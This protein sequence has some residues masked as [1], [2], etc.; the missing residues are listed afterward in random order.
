MTVSLDALLDTPF[1]AGLGIRSRPA[2][3][4]EITHLTLVE[5]ISDSAALSPGAVAVLTRGCG[6]SAGGYQLDVLIRRAAERDVAAVVLPC[7]V[8]RSPTAEHL[9]TRGRVILLDVDDELDPSNVVDGL[10]AAIAGDA[11]LALRRLAAASRRPPSAA[12]AAVIVGEIAEVTGIG[13]RYDPSGETGERVEVDGRTRGSVTT[14]DRDDSAII[15]TRLAALTVSQALTRSDRETLLPLRSTS[16]A[17]SHLLLCSQA[18]LANVAVRASETGLAV[19]GWH[20]AVRLVTL[21]PDHGEGRLAELEHEVIDIIAGMRRSGGASWSVVRPDDSLVLVL[22]TR[23]S[24]GR[25]G[26]RVVSE[27]V[28]TVVTELLTRHP[29]VSLRVGI[30][31]PHEGA[32]G[33]RVSAEES[34]TAV[35]SAGLSSGPVSVARF[36]SLG[37]RRMLAEWLVTDTA[38][39]TVSSLLAPLDALGPEKAGV[40][41][42]TLHTYLDERGSLQRAAARLNLHRNA[43]AYR[44]ANIS[45]VLRLDLDDPDQR[46]ALQLACR[47]RLMGTACQ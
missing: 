21:D 23:G 33:L 5:E 37:L 46:F 10:L 25:D 34:R 4:R 17:L 41:V 7:S 35:A 39:D 14:A 19:D 30:A 29:G 22:T 42:Q 32:A 11:R 2:D 13:L 1:G 40:A 20:C 26:G 16:V 24:P 45:E 47:A 28:D 9:A 27:T 15:A 18:N 36:D 3:P 43:V 31:T 8:R 12:D 44:M 38:R 6:R